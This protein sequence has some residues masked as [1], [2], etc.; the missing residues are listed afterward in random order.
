MKNIPE[1]P[2][3]GKPLTLPQIEEITHLHRL[4]GRPNPHMERDLKIFWRQAVARAEQAKRNRPTV[5]RF[6]RGRTARAPRPVRRVAVRVSTTA[7]ASSSS[8][9]PGGSSDG[10]PD[11]RLTHISAVLTTTL[12]QIFMPVRASKGALT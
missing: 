5:V 6:T 1:E 8:D 3:D 11:G 9:D 10:E 2:L 12:K 7:T 4:H